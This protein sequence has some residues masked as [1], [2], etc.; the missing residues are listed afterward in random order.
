MTNLY[1]WSETFT[2]QTGVISILMWEI[3]TWSYF[4]AIYEP[5]ISEHVNKSTK[6]VGHDCEKEKRQKDFLV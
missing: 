2:K 3:W 4:E 1:F 6:W 5:L